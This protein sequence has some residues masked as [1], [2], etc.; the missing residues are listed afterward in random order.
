MKIRHLCLK[1]LLLMSICV[2][3]EVH[4]SPDLLRQEA[5]RSRT[6]PTEEIDVQASRLATELGGGAYSYDLDAI[7]PIYAAYVRT[8][9]LSLKNHIARRMGP[10]FPRS[11]PHSASWENSADSIDRLLEDAGRAAPYF[12]EKCFEIAKKTHS[13]ANFGIGNASMI[14]SKKSLRLK[15]KQ[16]MREEGI[17]ES[18]TVKKI[19]D[20]L[21]GTIIADVP[22]QIP[23]IIQEI[24]DFAREEGEEVIFIN[25]WEENRP[26]GYVGIHAKMLLPI[27]DA[28]GLESERKI[29]IEIQIHLRCIMDGSSECV[30]EREH[31]LYEKH[32]LGESNLAYQRA[33]ST[34]LYLTVLKRCP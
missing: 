29:I 16:T 5:A 28:E 18:R 24:K 21:R 32:R 11:N 3:F 6:F 31:L 10:I 12:Q 19:R 15:V 4:A 34:L 8:E 13:I 7:V 26:S 2:Q 17:Q 20:A 1:L 27:H 25:A 30:K 33:A 14:K 23:S 22:E 9:W